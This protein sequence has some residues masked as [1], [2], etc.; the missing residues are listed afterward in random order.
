[1]EETNWATER[2]NITVTETDLR[3]LEKA[4][5]YE[6]KQKKKG[7]RWK[8]LDDRTKLFVECS[9]NGEPTELGKVQIQRAL[10][11]LNR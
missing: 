7:Y 10:E 8:V 6:K 5:Q 9:A 1:M 3:G 2:A 11:A 4:H